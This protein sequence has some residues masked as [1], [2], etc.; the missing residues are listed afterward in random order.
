MFTG[1]IEEVGRVA[2]IEQRGSGAQIRVV[3]AK[4]L[5]GTVV[6][7][8]ISTNGVC[9]TVAS[10][11]SDH[12]VADVMPETIRR[13]SFSSLRAGSPVNL[14]RA[15]VLGG[16]IG[17]HIVSGHIDGTGT[18]GS[19]QEDSDA[20]RLR[21]QADASITRSIV[22]KGSVAI[23]GIS[24][25]VTDVDDRGFGVSLIPHT[26]AATNLSTKRLGDIVN[27]E[28]DMIGKYVFRAL[29]AS[30]GASAQERAGITI[31]TL[32]ENGF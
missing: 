7:D 17:G 28:C 30:P 14:E 1:I 15:A 10:L 21:I 4:V 8:S 6:G 13:T 19:I 3:A 24:L 23:E 27:V 32:I 29:G 9:L 11:G 22:E 31:S 12:F 5:A 16:R 26:F 2:A 18:I 25:T 20:V